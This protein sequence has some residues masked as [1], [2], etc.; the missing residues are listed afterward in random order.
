MLL[1]YLD[2]S[3]RY[4]SYKIQTRSSIPSSSQAIEIVRETE[5]VEFSAVEN[6]SMFAPIVVEVV[7]YLLAK[8]SFCFFTNSMASR[9]PVL[10]SS[11]C[12][13]GLS[14]TTINS[15]HLLQLLQSSVN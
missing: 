12:N 13:I 14:A 4:C 10:D 1:N 15:L 5:V 2:V 8:R 11:M 9:S 7:T 3:L 6:G